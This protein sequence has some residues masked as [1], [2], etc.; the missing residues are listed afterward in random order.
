MTY[1]EVLIR[2]GKRGAAAYVQVRTQDQSSLT[3]SD[4]EGERNLFFPPS[5]PGKFPP[6]KIRTA[7]I[8]MYHE[9]EVK[10]PNLFVSLFFFLR[11]SATRPSPSPPSPRNTSSPCW[12]TCSTPR[13][14][15]TTRTPSIGCAG[16]LEVDAPTTTSPR[17][18]NRNPLSLK[19][20][21]FPK[22]IPHFQS[23]STT[24]PPC[25][26]SCGPPTLWRSAAAP[27][28]SPSACRS[29]PT[30]SSTA[31]TRATTSTCSRVRP[32]APATAAMPP[33]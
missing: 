32:G 27:A 14:P 9:H 24:T 13:S 8:F 7:I 4:R 11:R 33:S 1:A 29:A 16:L 26:A 28:G 21:I 6:V 2:K 18:V 31:T 5:I 3:P 30:A 20:T 19:T 25:A 17:M 22:R 23:G 10:R 15:S 12:T